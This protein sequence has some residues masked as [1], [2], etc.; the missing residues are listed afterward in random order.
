M[1]KILIATILLSVNLTS[2][3]SVASPLSQLKTYYH[4]HHVVNRSNEH[5]NYDKLVTILKTKE[6]HPKRTLKPEDLDNLF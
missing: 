6:A 2:T 5:A 4:K 1:K 3:A